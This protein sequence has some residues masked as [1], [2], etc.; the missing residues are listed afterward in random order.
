MAEEIDQEKLV[1][2]MRSSTQEVFS[3]MLGMEVTAGEP[4]MQASKP[5]PADGVVS[6][7][8]LAGNWVGTGSICCTAEFAC[9]ICGHM[10]MSEYASVNQDVLDAMGEVTN[11]IVGNFKLAMEDYLGPMGL[12]IPMVIFGHNFTARSVNNTDGRWFRSNA[13]ADEWK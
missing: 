8:G 6:L 12:S 2:A 1:A 3:T 4:F 9:K 7:V 11:M 5:G 13:R 10:L